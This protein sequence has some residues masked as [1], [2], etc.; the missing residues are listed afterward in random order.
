MGNI[1]PH[2]LEAC[3]VPITNALPCHSDAE[4]LTRLMRGT[5]KVTDVV[6]APES[7]SQPQHVKRSSRRDR[8]AEE[9]LRGEQGEN[10]R[11]DNIKAPKGPLLRRSKRLRAQ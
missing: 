8:H 3:P 6:P 2:L 1:D 9:Q 5:A 7:K 11:L 4:I 10:K